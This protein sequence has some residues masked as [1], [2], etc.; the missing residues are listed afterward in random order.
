MREFDASTTPPSLALPQNGLPSSPILPTIAPLFWGGIRTLDVIDRRAALPGSASIPAKRLTAF[1]NLG[2]MDAPPT[3]QN[4]RSYSWRRPADCLRG[5]YVAAALGARCAL[6]GGPPYSTP[7][8]TPYSNPSDPAA[9]K[10]A[11]SK[12]TRAS[13][14]PAN[15]LSG[16]TAT[17]TEL[18]TVMAD[19]QQ[20]GAQD[21]EAQQ[22][23]LEDLKRTDPSLWPQLIRAFRSSMAYRQQ[24]AARLAQTPPAQQPASTDVEYRHGDRPAA[25]D[26]AAGRVFRYAAVSDDC[27]S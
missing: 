18:A 1:P 17:P 11:A 7:Y 20:I 21:P 12:A 25:V 14:N 2:C 27:H 6:F 5:L 19:V 15:A 8:S 10:S 24:S 23:L 9:P 13:T 22:A 4:L 26:D 16:T 3:F